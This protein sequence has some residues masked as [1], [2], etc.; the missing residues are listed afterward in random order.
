MKTIVYLLK[1]LEEMGIT[2]FFGLPGDY[3]FNIV[4]QIQ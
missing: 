1:K 2:D 4:S 3:N